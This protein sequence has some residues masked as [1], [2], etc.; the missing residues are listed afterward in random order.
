[1]FDHVEI[2]TAHFSASRHFYETVL[3]PLRIEPKWANELEAGFGKM[4]GDQAAFLVAHDEA[5]PS[6]PCHLAFR[7]AHQSEVDAFYRAGIQA[8]FRCNGKPGLRKHYSP[9]YYAA[10]LFDPDGNNIEAVVY[11]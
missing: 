6:G 7:A 5:A 2:R 11:L 1:M 3:R 9:N 4:N 10:F 8:G